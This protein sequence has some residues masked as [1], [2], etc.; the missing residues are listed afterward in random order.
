[1]KHQDL[2]NCLVRWHGALSGSPAHALVDE[3]DAAV[4]AIQLQAYA[5]GRR[6]ERQEREAWEAMQSGRF[7]QIADWNA[8]AMKPDTAESVQASAIAENG[9]MQIPGAQ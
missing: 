8:E 3:V 7:D 6:D 9:S 2:W 5:D 4:D 1:M